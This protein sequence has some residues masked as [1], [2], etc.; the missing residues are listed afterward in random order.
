MCLYNNSAFLVRLEICSPHCPELSAVAG[1]IKNMGRNHTEVICPVPQGACKGSWCQLGGLWKSASSHPALAV[2]TKGHGGDKG[3]PQLDGC[4]VGRRSSLCQGPWF[5]Q[6]DIQPERALCAHGCGDE[7]K[8][9]GL[10]SLIKSR[11][12][13]RRNRLSEKGTSN[14]KRVVRK[15]MDFSTCKAEVCS[16]FMFVLLL[17]LSW[18]ISKSLKSSHGSAITDA[19]I[20]QQHLSWQVTGQSAESRA[21]LLIWLTATWH[22]P[23]GTRSNLAPRSGNSACPGNFKH[24]MVLVQR[25]YLR[26]REKK[27]SRS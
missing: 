21:Q 23:P 8:F 5:R 3:T 20:T 4:A 27:T 10:F 1:E 19:L 9:M 13:L 7:Q 15:F 26:T 16:L 2:G 22:L 12:H 6:T 25:G 11:G 24:G 18:D 14:G 17:T